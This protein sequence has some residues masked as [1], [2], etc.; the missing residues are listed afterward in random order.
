VWYNGKELDILFSRLKMV[1][2][3]IL[4]ACILYSCLGLEKPLRLGK[5]YLG[6]RRLK[7]VYLCSRRLEKPYLGFGRPS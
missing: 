5:A 6:L 7:K 1:R 4:H 2:G 3:S